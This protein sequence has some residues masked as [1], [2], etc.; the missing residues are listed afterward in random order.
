MVSKFIGKYKNHFDTKFKVADVEY[1]VNQ[2]R[3]LFDLNMDTQ[4]LEDVLKKYLRVVKSQVRGQSMNNIPV[5]RMFR[6]R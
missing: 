1:G 5:N 6:L 4:V 2:S 3:A